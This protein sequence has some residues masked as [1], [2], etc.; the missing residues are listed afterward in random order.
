MKGPVLPWA[1]LALSKWGAVTAPERCVAGRDSCSAVC[2]IPQ[3]PPTQHVP[4][5]WLLPCHVDPSG[6]HT[7]PIA[8]QVDSGWVFSQSPPCW[9]TLCSSQTGYHPSHQKQKQEILL[10]LPSECPKN[11]QLLVTPLWPL[12]PNASYISNPIDQHHLLQNTSRIQL[13]L[14]TSTSKTRAEPYHLFS[15]LF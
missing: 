6:C 13:L 5:Q 9:G 10:A 7:Q 8:R 4:V 3:T 14:T 2:D 11:Q 15:R 12:S 1:C